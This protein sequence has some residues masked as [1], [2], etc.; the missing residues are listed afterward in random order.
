MTGRHQVV[1]KVVDAVGQCSH[2]RAELVVMTVLE[3]VESCSI[4][5]SCVPA[6]RERD[7]S[8]E[9]MGELVDRVDCP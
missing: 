3:S 8:F 9:S 7:L 5:T 1:D 2:I 6:G 4:P